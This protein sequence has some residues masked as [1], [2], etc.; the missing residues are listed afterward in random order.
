MAIK[1]NKNESLFRNELILNVDA[2]TINIDNT[3]VN[4]FM[5][6]K[7]NGMKPK[8]R[9]KNG[10]SLEVD[11]D[12]I[13]N[14]FKALEDLGEVEG[15]SENKLAI[16]IWIRQ[17]LSNMV[18]R[19]NM[20]KEKISSLKPIH[21]ES[22]RI[23]NAKNT[24]DY[25]SA[26]QVYLMLGQKPAI[27]E[28]LRKYLLEGWDAQTN[29]FLY[30]NSLDVD[31]LGILHL[32]KRINPGFIESNTSLNNILPLLPHQAELFCD[33]IRRL[34]VYKKEIPRS[35]L[36]EY[37]KTITSFHLALYSFKVMNYLPKMVD[38]NSIDVKDDWK[39]VVDVTDNFDSKISA[40]AIADAEA[41]Y[42]GIYNYV[43]TTLQ[44]N[45]VIGFNNLEKN[46][47]KSL[48]KAINIITE[49]KTELEFNFNAVWNH[50]KGMQDKED[51]EIINDMVKYENSSFDKYIEIVMKL[52]G[53]YQLKYYPQFLDSISQKN[54]DRG[55]LAQGRSKKHPRRFVLGTRLLEALVQIQVLYLKNDKFSTQN[56]SIE[57]L[58][59]NLKE[60]YG[61]VI[62]GLNEDNYKNADVNTNLA[63]KENVEAFKSKLRQIGF[64]NDMSD[65]YILQKVRPRYELK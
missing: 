16:E 62:N 64:Y 59:E 45:N 21:L 49:E 31:S 34:L 12:K 46:N 38:Q 53:A 65:A 3:L 11:I 50:F 56:I 39:V 40:F 42:N 13:Y 52:K 1:I 15:V 57:D 35:V 23:R 26:D 51:F 58:M 24:R 14:Y 22:Y 6:L 48:I 19:G 25:Y 20:E 33:D 17:N 8:Q 18:N 63:F 41:N 36:I 55:F 27:K 28:E 37:I 4:L 2:K 47:S 60:R 9:A 61:L 32:I 5:L 29:E 30:S 10:Q 43:K 54:S 44:I 7:H